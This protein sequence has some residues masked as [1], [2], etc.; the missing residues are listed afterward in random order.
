M[1]GFEVYSCR[2]KRKRKHGSYMQADLRI[3]LIKF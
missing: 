2:V 1:T 3:I